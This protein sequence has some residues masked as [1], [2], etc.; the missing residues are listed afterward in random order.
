MPFAILKQIRG[1]NQLTELV[2]NM[3][4]NNILYF[5]TP[6]I[7]I[8][9]IK[10]APFHIDGEPR[11]SSSEFDIKMIPNCFQLIQPI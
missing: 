10:L 11:E 7:K 1:N 2:E 5:Q 8:R 6:S 9:N 3:G 4:N